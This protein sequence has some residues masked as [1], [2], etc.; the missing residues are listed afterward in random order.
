MGVVALCFEVECRNLQNA[1]LKRK[2]NYCSES[3][4]TSSQKQALY[5]RMSQ[6][7]LQIP[8]QT[9]KPCSITKLYQM[10]LKKPIIIL[11]RMLPPPK[12]T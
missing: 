8:T 5:N 10:C 9:I 11:G 1:Y 2:C 12:F 6:F 4:V 7:A 3:N